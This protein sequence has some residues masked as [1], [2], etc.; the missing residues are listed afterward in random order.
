MVYLAA[1]ADGAAGNLVD[2]AVSAKLNTLVQQVG[3]VPGLGGELT[4]LSTAPSQATVFAP[5]DAAFTYFSTNSKD[6][7]AYVSG[8]QPYQIANLEKVLKYHVLAG[9]VLSAAITGTATEVTTLEGQKISAQV[10]GTDVVITDANNRTA[11]VTSPDVKTTGDASGAKTSVAHVIDNV[12]LPLAS[13]LFANQTAQDAV[14]GAAAD[15]LD[16]VKFAQ[17]MNNLKTLVTQIGKVDGLANAIL[18]AGR[19]G[20]TLLAPTEAAFAK[21]IAGDPA[22]AYDKYVGGCTGSSG[23]DWC[24]D[25]LG[26]IL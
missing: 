23:D 20:A 9:E 12:L 13:T 18:D 21:L 14:D 17:G 10:Q 16:F 2:L 1:P 26:Q 6:L 24:I 3:R 4:G 25:N 15:K 5:D 11:K 7:W 8:N 22:G 19:G